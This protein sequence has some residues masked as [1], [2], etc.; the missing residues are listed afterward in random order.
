MGNVTVT[1]DINASRS[2]VWSVLAD[3]PNIHL[4]NSGIKHSESTSDA[5]HGVGAQRYCD[6]KP[7]GRV[8]ETIREWEPE[9]RIV[10]SIDE[11]KG[12]PIRSGLAA[13]DLVDD[14]E[15]TQVTLS[16]D[17]DLKWGP[18]GA[19][20]GPIMKGQLKKGFGGFLAD[21]EVAAQAAQPA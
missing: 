7:A 19:L 4:W 12:L 9:S 16:Y 17:Y 15:S 5:G 1:K 20:M 8:E 6:L 11:S 14:A 13:F 18:I 10:I 21:L 3:Y 2:A